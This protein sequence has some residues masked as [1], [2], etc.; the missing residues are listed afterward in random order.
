MTA[1]GTV[2]S[3]ARNH[4]AGRVAPGLAVEGVAGP[5]TVGGE[6]GAVGMGVS[7]RWRM[8][9]PIAKRIARQSARV[10]RAISRSI[11]QPAARPPDA[12][13]P[14][15]LSVALIDAVSGARTEAIDGGSPAQRY[16]RHFAIARRRAGRWWLPPVCAQE[17]LSDL[18][19]RYE[20]LGVETMAAAVFRGP[21]R[22]AGTGHAGAATVLGLARALRRLGIETLQ[23]L[24]ARRPR[25]LDAALRAEA[26][27]DARTVRLLLSYGGADDFVWGDAAVRGFVA[28]ALGRES[29]S[30]ARAELLVRRAAYELILSPRHVDYR[31]W[32]RAYVAPG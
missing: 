26:G 15:H 27:F 28:R 2:G 24:G 6:Y 16:C 23:D 8:P 19:T 30:A 4:G 17:P 10:M 29:V 3:T 1:N 32:S 25:A 7:G 14:A 13:F 12:F 22:P 31:I 5:G 9:A 18:V 21:A 11:A 20:R